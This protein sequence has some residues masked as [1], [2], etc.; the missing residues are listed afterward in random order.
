MKQHE[1]L[2]CERMSSSTPSVTHSVEGC[3]YLKKAY[4]ASVVQGY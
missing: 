1:A 4:I 3:G 2:F